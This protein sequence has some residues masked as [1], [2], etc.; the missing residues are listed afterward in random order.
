M[1]LEN[2]P[3]D[4][5]GSLLDAL[6]EIDKDWR[7]KE[8]VIVCGSH[9]VEDYEKKLAI[10]KDARERDVPCL[11]ICFGL[12]LMAIEYARF[13]GLEEATSQ[14]IDPKAVMPVVSKLPELRVGIRKVNGRYENHW[15]NYAVN[16]DF[17]D[18]FEDFD[19]TFADN[20]KI[21]E[22]IRHKR[23]RFHVGVQFHPEYRKNH[24]ILR[25]FLSHCV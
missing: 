24:P 18:G 10:I 16:N 22:V 3:Q 7:K 25:E 9:S 6:T 15:H 19:V 12:Q 8:G 21:V 20:E 13:K 17:V 2:N 23:N 5:D 14:E 4:L 1:L 11:G